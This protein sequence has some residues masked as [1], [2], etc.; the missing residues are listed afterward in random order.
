LISMGHHG[1]WVHRRWCGC[2][3]DQ[4]IHPLLSCSRRC[5]EA[6]SFHTRLATSHCG[7]I[8]ADVVS[9]CIIM[10]FFNDYTDYTVIYTRCLHVPQNI[11]KLRSP[12]WRFWWHS[13]KAA[14]SSSLC[15]GRVIPMKC[16]RFCRFPCRFIKGSYGSYK[17][18]HY[19][20]SFWGMKSPM[21]IP[22]IFGSRS[23][24]PRTYHQPTELLNTAQ[25]K[26]EMRNRKPKDSQRCVF[27]CLVSEILDDFWRLHTQIYPYSPSKWMFTSD[28]GF[29]AVADKWRPSSFEMY[30][31]THRP[32]LD[33]ICCSICRVHGTI[34]E[35][36]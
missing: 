20:P 26:H 24:N 14:S 34:S 36:I 18:K 25:M 28:S 29:V 23:Y 21:I 31:E 10:L 22:N 16:W 17:K 30:S 1:S 13:L 6:T 33:W 9:I 5:C 27:P 7:A 11:W 19:W 4:W 3:M 35:P 32:L 8:F 2:T 12:P 15:R